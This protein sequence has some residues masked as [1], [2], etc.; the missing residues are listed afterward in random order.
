LLEEKCLLLRAYPII[1]INKKIEKFNMGIKN[2]DF[3]AGFKSVAT[4][5]KFTQK[6]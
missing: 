1:K 3:D 6:S 5:K 4:A 2:A